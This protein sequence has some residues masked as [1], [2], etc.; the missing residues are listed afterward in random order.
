VSGSGSATLRKI[1]L[2][3]MIGVDP[4]IA[5]MGSFHRMFSVPLAVH[6]V[7]RFFSVLRPLCAGPRQCG[8]LSARIAIVAADR[9]AIVRMVFFIFIPPGGRR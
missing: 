9:N 3:Q 6:L 4:D 7:G 8:Q 2:P 1:R 5:G